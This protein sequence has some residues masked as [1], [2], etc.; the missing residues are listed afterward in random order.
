MSQRVTCPH[1]EKE[2]EVTATEG[3]VV[4]CPSCRQPFK[5][6]V[7]PTAQPPVQM[8]E[9]S[10][11]RWKLLQ[12]I[13]GVGIVVGLFLASVGFLRG[14]YADFNL[15]V[16]V[17]WYVIAGVIVVPSIVVYYYGRIAAW[18]YHG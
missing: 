6:P 7:I 16:S 8:I 9:Q 4:A 1:C 2:T 13:G 14:A 11:K 18:W 12:L 15:G 17:G 3:A 10:A 5:V